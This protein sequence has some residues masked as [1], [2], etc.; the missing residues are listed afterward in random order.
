M[1]I[2]Y[3]FVDILALDLHQLGIL[4]EGDE[5]V[6]ECAG[7]ALGIVDTQ[8]QRHSC[9]DGISTTVHGAG[10]INNDQ[11]VLAAREVL[12]G[13]PGCVDGLALLIRDIATAEEGLDQLVGRQGIGVELLRSLGDTFHECTIPIAIISHEGL[14]VLE[15]GL[16]GL[17]GVVEGV[18]FFS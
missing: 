2:P 11:S 6:L 4:G 10:A 1:T 13:L 8:R 15:H 12:L 17:L 7:V 14:S 3:L 9:G 16:R 18:V 5:V